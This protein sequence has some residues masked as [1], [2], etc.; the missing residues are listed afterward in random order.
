MNPDVLRHFHPVLPA[1]SLRRRPVRVQV[2]GRAYALFRDAGGRPAALDDLCPHRHAP[3][4]QGRVRPDGRLAC[5]YHGWHFDREGRGRSPGCPERSDCGTRSWQVAERYGYLWLAERGTPLAALPD[6]GGDGFELAGTV[7]VHIP[8]PIELTLDNITEDEHFAHVH[9]TFGWNEEGLS[10]VIV[11]TDRFDDRTEVRYTGPQRGSFWSHLGG[12]RAGDRFHNQW[13]TRFEPVETVYTFWWEDP[14]TGKQR[15]VTTRAAVFLVPETSA[16]TWL[17][18]FIFVRVAPS[19][20]RPF[21]RVVHWLSRHIAA[22]EL[23]QDAWILGQVAGAPSDLRGMRLTRFD[24]ALAHNRK[25]LKT[26]YWKAG[27][28]SG[29]G[30]RP[31]AETVPS[32]L[33]VVE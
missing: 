23:E 32:A 31:F 12:V 3:L 2:A 26:V 6:F 15:P 28:A 1:R 8:A 24:R 30:S 25:L 33:E 20:L 27:T 19:L 10:R 4:S 5:P 7:P 16:T 18:M 22:K 11:E 17:H 29:P 14:E 21:R 9:S 13:V